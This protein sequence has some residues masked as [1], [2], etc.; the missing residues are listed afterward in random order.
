MDIGSSERLAMQ[1]LQIPDTAETRIVP[2]WLFPP[3][4]PDKNRFTSGRPD[5]VLVAPIS[6][7]SKKQQTSNE[8]GLILRS[9]REQ[10]WEIRSTSAAPPSATSRSTFARQ[11]RPNVSAFSNVT[12]T[13]SSTVRTLDHRIS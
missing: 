1:N 8:G 12:F 6:A 10:L 11:H 9:G 3:R 4:F 5:A 2:K 13:S 7:K